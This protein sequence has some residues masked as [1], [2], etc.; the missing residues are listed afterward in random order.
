MRKEVDK[1]PK[2]PGTSNAQ[3]VVDFRPRQHSQGNYI[4]H[5]FHQFELR[6]AT[7]SLSGDAEAGSEMLRA[8]TGQV[9]RAMKR[10][11]ERAAIH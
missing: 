7:K 6:R 2:T 10:S 3:R 8:L 1:R 4:S 5:H 11:H 9:C